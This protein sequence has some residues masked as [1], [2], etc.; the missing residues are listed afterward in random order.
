VGF[1]SIVAFIPLMILLAISI[2]GIILI[3]LIPLL[4]MGGFILGFTV[5]GNLAGEQLARALRRDLT[6]PLKAVLGLLA[7]LVILKVVTIVPLLGWL[8]AEIAKMLIRTA[9]LGLL[10]TIIWEA[11]R[12]KK[13]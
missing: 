12:K 2:V 13:A 11:S 5:I 10:C 8:T 1:F 9:G 3:P 7:L 4:Y 6:Q